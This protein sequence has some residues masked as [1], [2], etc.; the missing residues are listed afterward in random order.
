MKKPR[1]VRHAE[2]VKADERADVAVARGA[3][4]LGSLRSLVRQ[5]ERIGGYTTHEQ[6]AELRE[7]RALI[8][9]DG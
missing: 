3:R 5:L 9:E 2:L 8:A 6:Q 4:A 1:M 7:A